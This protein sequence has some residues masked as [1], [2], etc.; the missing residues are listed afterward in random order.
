MLLTIEKA[1]RISQEEA[2][3]TFNWDF[4]EMLMK[5]LLRDEGRARMTRDPEAPSD[6]QWRDAMPLSSPG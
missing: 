5:G 3:G 6:S 1:L 2:D 4:E